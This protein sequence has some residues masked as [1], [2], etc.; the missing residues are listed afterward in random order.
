[1]TINNFYQLDGFR[2]TNE[3]VE[4]TI[5]KQAQLLAMI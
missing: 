5:E 1:M 2:T 3:Y 4:E